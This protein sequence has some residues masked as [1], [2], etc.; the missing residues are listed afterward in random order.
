MFPGRYFFL[1]DANSKLPDTPRE[2]TGGDGVAGSM[3]V[4]TPPV[5]RT[6]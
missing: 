1:P 6:V 3:G 4:N 2:N 5:R